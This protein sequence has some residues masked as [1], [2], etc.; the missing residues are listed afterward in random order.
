VA[1]VSLALAGKKGGFAVLGAAIRLPRTGAWTAD[2]EV[3]S[4]E[5]LT[6]KVDLQIGETTFKGQVARGALTRG[7][8]RAR[9][10]AGADGL[11][12]KVS[13]RHYTGPTIGIVLRDVAKNAGE[14]V[15]GTASASVL[16]T[17]LGHWTTMAHPAGQA[18]YNLMLSAPADTVWR[19]LPDGSIWA[20]TD[21]F[22]DSGIKDYVEI[23]EE[24][25]TG[26]VDVG[27]VTPLLFPGTTLGG[28]RVGSVEITVTGSDVR[29][30]IWTAE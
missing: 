14:L 8:F 25:Q 27:L 21:A 24:P 18:I 23:G 3:D 6:G 4:R 22:A 17:Q 10:V 7:L 19:F 9:V 30:K 1:H 15:S 11:R 12:T 13:P 16:G 2:L 5:P 20:G 28:R 26:V 29:A